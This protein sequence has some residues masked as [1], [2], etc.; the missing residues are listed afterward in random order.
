VIKKII[1]WNFIELTQPLTKYMQKAGQ[2][3]SPA[4]N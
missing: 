4:S 3:I 2:G 1:A